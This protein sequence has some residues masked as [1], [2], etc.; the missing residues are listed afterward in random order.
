MGRKRRRTKAN[1]ARKQ[2]APT[3]GKSPTETAGFNQMDGAEVILTSLPRIQWKNWHE[4]GAI[5]TRIFLPVNGGDGSDDDDCRE[6][7]V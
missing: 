6:F 2:A 3:T 5:R 7:F 1:P 4:A